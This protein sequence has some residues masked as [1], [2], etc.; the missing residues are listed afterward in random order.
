MF[1]R[2]GPKTSRPS[3]HRSSCRRFAWPRRRIA[4]GTGR[5]TKAGFVSTDF[6]APDIP[7]YVV[8]ELRYESPVAFSRS[9]FAAP[10]AAAPQ[11]DTLNNVLANTT[12]APC[13]PTSVLPA[14][15]SGRRV[16]VAATLPQ[17]PEPKKFAK[18]G[19]DAEFIQSGFVQV[20]PEERQRRAEDRAGAEPEGRGVAGVRRAP[21]GAGGGA[22]RIAAPAAGT[23]SRHR[24]ICTR[25][26]TASARC[27]VWA[28]RWSEGQRA[29]RSATSKATG[30]GGTKICR[31]A[32]PS[33]AAR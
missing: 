13:A 17:E 15:R 23:S 12:S 33:S 3:L 28:A 22:G 10:A 8:V 25:R 19:L 11:A 31:R 2:R 5:H 30:T 4:R 20:V 18:K 21:A 16:E 1:L 9:K 32:S 6:E 27:E 7:D 14:R 24:A 26:Q 29:S